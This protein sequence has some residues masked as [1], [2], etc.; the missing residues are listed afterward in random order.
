[1]NT[2]EH[3]RHWGEEEIWHT[4]G[5]QCQQA[6]LYPPSKEDQMG[7]EDGAH[8]FIVTGPKFGCIH[9]EPKGLQV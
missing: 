7:I 9:W 8:A 2:C 1:M 4:K 5:R 6:S 3:C